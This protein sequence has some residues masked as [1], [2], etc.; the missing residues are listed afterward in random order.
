MLRKIYIGEGGR[1]LKTRIAED[2]RDC[3]IGNNNT[4]L[5]KHIW[6]LDHF[7]DFDF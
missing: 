6:T 7:F 5:S 3:T 2:K 4:G 1:R